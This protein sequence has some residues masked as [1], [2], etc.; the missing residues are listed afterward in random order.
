MS[1]RLYG[2]PA[3]RRAT[4]TGG[5]GGQRGGPVL[6]RRNDQGREGQGDGEVQ[7]PLGGNDRT[8]V[9]AGNGGQVKTTHRV[10]PAPA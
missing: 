2:S 6:D 7:L 5:C 3:A 1:P 4:H 10:R 9:R 8:Q